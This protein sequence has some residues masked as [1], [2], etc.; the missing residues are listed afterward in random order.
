[1]RNVGDRPLITTIGDR[2]IASVP[3]LT[4]GGESEGVEPC[5][6]NGIPDNYLWE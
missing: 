3:V 2:R 4:N 1:M 5:Y 6:K